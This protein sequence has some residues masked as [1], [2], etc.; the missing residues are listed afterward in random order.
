MLKSCVATQW[1]TH[2]SAEII[3]EC[4]C[5]EIANVSLQRNHR[6]SDADKW[7][8]WVKSSLLIIDNLASDGRD[9]LNSFEIQSC[10]QLLREHH[11]AGGCLVVTMT[12]DADALGEQLRARLGNFV[13]QSLLEYNVDVIKLI[14]L[15]YRTDLD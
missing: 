7:Q 10:G 6:E 8:R 1:F 12:A 13:Y 3:C 9:S 14:G 4:T 5:S 15:S 2:S 11:R